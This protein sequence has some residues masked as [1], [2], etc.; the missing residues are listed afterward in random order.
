MA[1]RLNEKYSK[2]MGC[3]TITII[4]H[5]KAKVESKKTSRSTI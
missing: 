2:S 5:K 4:G 3:P 1:S